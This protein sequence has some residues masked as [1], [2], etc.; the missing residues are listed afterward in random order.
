MSFVDC[1]LSVGCI[2]ISFAIFLPGTGEYGSQVED[3]S[4]TSYGQ[5]PLKKLHPRIL[6]RMHSAT[7]NQLSNTVRRGGLGAAKAPLVLGNEG[8]GL[9]EES[10]RFKPGTRIAIYGAGELGITQDGLFQQWVIVE[11]R[12]ILPDIINWDEGAALTVNYL[13]AYQSLTRIAKCAEGSE[14]PYFRCYGL[15]RAWAAIPSQWFPPRKRHIVPETWRSIRL[16]ARCWANCSDPS[17]RLRFLLETVDSVATAIGGDRVAVRISP[18][19]RIHDAPAYSS[20]RQSFLALTEEL[21]KRK[22]SYLT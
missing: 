16:E 15:G 20:E 11:D 9:V 21:S 12:R 14:D 7:I 1:C 13:T 4:R 19:A 2:S 10:G 6:V 18:E 8:S 22:I 5:E 3:S 17:V